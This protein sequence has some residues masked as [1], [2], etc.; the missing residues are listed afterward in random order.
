MKNKESLEALSV[1]TGENLIEGF[2]QRI[3]KPEKEEIV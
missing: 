2:K 1:L 3:Q